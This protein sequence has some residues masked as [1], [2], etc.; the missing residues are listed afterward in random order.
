MKYVRLYADAN[1]ESHFEEVNV[2]FALGDY[3]PPTPSILISS[4]V[5]ALQFGFLGAPPGWVGEW[6][7]VPRRQ[8]GFIVAGEMELEASD[9][10]VRRLPIGSVALI[11]DTAGRGH[12]TR[13]VGTEDCTMAVVHL[14][15]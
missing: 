7:P 4:F 1:G 13:I 3:S 11:E 6:H 8:M 15:E 5:A 9:G 14:P 12:V 2:E 10:E